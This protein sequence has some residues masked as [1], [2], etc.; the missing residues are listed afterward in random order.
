M[1]EIVKTSES[2]PAASG[3]NHVVFKGYTLEELRYQRALIALKKDF[4]QAKLMRSLDTVQKANPLSATNR[5]S[6]LNSKF[7][8]VASRIF[9]GL[10]YLDYAMMGFSFF[11]SVRKV[12]GFFH[13]KK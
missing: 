1:K 3:E 7:G 8:G 5:I 4:S 2:T 12:Y 10:N 6:S 13:K 9:S 11:N